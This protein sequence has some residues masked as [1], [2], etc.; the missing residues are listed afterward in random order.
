MN[1]LSRRELFRRSVVLAGASAGMGLLRR[2]QAQEA[3]KKPLDV[4]II[5][6]GLAGLV[7][8]YEL[9]KR[10][11]R[12][13]LLEAEKQ[14]VGGRART[15]RFGDG[16]YGEAGA[17]RI[18]EKH[19]V[20]RHYV[21]ELGLALRKFV[22][23]NLNGYYY[24]RGR[25]VRISEWARLQEAYDLRP[26]EKG[27]SPDDLWGMTVSQRLKALSPA[28][29][30]DLLSAAFQTPGARRIEQLTFRQ[31]MD[32]LSPEALEFLMTT[33]GQE[34]ELET[35]ADE[36]LREEY[37]ELW[38][39][40]FDEIVGGTDRLA[41]GF[42]DRLR[43]KPRMGCEVTRIVQTGDK[44]GAIYV[45]NGQPQR[46]EGDFLICTIP[47]PVLMRVEF[48]P[49]I[50]AG[51]MRAIR[52]LS[53]DSATKVLAVCNKRFWETDDGIFGGGTF[54]DLP[55]GTAYY[56]ANNA[57]KREADV[58]NGPGVL[59]ASYT[60]GHQARRLGAMLEKERSELVIQ[61]LAKVHPQLL[62]PAIVRQTA[63]WSWDQ[64]R[65]SLGA[66]AW[67]GP[68]EHSALYPSLL[69]PEGRV[70]LAGE[71]ASLSHTWMQGALE[72]GLRVVDELLK[73]NG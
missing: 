23:S 70:Y 65:Y 50:S 29:Q 64:H 6:A 71:H 40:S 54:T 67:F 10:G 66:F 43:S 18:P 56:P 7:C 47:L 52:E 11:H 26:G 38:S 19:D 3:G 28:E 16:L 25:K 4:V 73:R 30:R 15:L 12:I 1:G 34:T 60:W 37:K 20:T 21:K 69:T 13:T 31:L 51:K 22:Q 53:Y 5:G 72:S 59:L 32:T 49:A 68:G 24:G 62:A 58:S 35:G 14:H 48:E 63:S 41:A 33:Q 36:T 42:A 55:C 39:L 17:M 61:S 8:A 9:E 46:V 45:E 44:A 57:Q 27:K 2:V